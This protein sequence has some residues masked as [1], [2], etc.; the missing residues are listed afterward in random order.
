M[1]RYE[2]GKWGEVFVMRRL[3]ENGWKV[4]WGRKGLD[5]DLVACYNESVIQIEVKTATRGKD[6]KWRATLM[7]AGKYGSTDHNKADVVILIC[8]NNAELTYYVI[9]TKDIKNR[10]H[11]VITSNPRTYTGRWSKYRRESLV[12]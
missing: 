11:L 5:S 4:S 12:V 1:T 7:K 8:Q 2:L 3:L 9:P 10:R 6:S